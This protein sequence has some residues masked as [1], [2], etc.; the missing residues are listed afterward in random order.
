MKL[1]TVR[2]VYF[3]NSS[4]GLPSSLEALPGL[5]WNSLQGTQDLRALLTSSQEDILVLIPTSFLSLQALETFVVWTEQHPR[6]SFIF[7]VQAME[8]TA[9]RMTLSNSQ[10]VIAYESEGPRI[11][12]IVT[13]RL[14]RQIVKSRK[15]ERHSLKT[16]VMLKKSLVSKTSPTGG[17]VQYLKEGMMQDFSP[18]GAK[19]AL[20]K[21]GVK[22]KDFVSLMYR[23]SQGSWVSV[24]SQ[25]RWVISTAAGEQVIGVQFLAVSA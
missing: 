20:S 4:Q 11:G 14:L 21:A 10:M 7:I 25:V 13:R 9:Y 8:N 12:E 22:V 23:N 2:D 1:V 15:Q 3:L 6:L 16:G 19:I 17:G 18:G 5:R 24:E